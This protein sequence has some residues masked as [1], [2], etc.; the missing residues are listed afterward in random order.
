M[1][2]KERR[3][4]D[5]PLR[6]VSPISACFR[7]IRFSMRR[8]GTRISRQGG[9]GPAPRVEFGV[10]AG[11]GRIRKNLRQCLAAAKFITDVTVLKVTLP[12]DAVRQCLDPPPEPRFPRLHD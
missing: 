9:R 3:W 6:Q 2:G 12:P 8:A 5:R 10:E 7:V 4:P 1:L 11:F